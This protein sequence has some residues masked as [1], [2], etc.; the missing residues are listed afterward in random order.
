MDHSFHLICHLKPLCSCPVGN[1]EMPR[2][3]PIP[4]VTVGYSGDWMS[5]SP[6]AL[7]FWVSFNSQGCVW[8]VPDGLRLL[9]FVLG[10]L[11]KLN[12]LHK[13]SVWHPSFHS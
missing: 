13:L 9:G 5:L 6:I 3:Q 8:T 7:Q 1:E 2:A 12:F 11:E 10:L 4:S